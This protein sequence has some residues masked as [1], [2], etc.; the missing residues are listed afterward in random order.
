MDD[1]SFMQVSEDFAHLAS[2]RANLLFTHTTIF[3]YNLSQILAVYVIQNQITSM[4]LK[5][6]VVHFYNLVA[7][8]LLK[9]AGFQ[10]E[11]LERFFLYCFIGKSRYNCLLQN[12]CDTINSITRHISR[13]LPTYTQSPFNYVTPILQFLS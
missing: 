6:I 1:G 3:V 13:T 4:V 10:F 11:P 7:V 2:E 9:H 8:Q 12:Y 5:K